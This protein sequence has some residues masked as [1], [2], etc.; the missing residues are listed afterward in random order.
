MKNPHAKRHE[1]TAPPP[2]KKQNDRR[3]AAREPAGTEGDP[4][5]GDHASRRSRRPAH[6]KHLMHARASSLG[7][8]GVRVY[9]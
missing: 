3:G 1:G 7:Q 8:G 9:A 4:R 5:V 6:P 2:V